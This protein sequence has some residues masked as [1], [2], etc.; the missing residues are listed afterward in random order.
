[1]SLKSDPNEIPSQVFSVNAARRMCG[2]WRKALVAA[3]VKGGITSLYDSILKR[4]RAALGLSSTAVL[5]T[6][7]VLCLACLPAAFGAAWLARKRREASP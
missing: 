5:S 2:S 6:V 3:G 1:M 4:L 7:L